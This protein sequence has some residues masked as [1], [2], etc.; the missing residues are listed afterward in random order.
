MLEASRLT[1]KFIK[2]NN[3]LNH[4]DN[5]REFALYRSMLTR[6]EIEALSY[7]QSL[8]I[9]GNKE[10]PPAETLPPD[11]PAMPP[12]LKEQAGERRER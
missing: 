6:D 8:T 5:P 7:V 12:P 2:T 3:P 1:T 9:N 11:E 4:A 10:E